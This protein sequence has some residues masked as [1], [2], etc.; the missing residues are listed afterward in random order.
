M[1]PQCFPAKYAGTCCQC[2]I[3]FGAGSPVAFTR[4]TVRSHRDGS[5]RTW[6]KHAT[7]VRHWDCRPYMAARARQMQLAEVALDIAHARAL[8]A[9]LGFDAAQTAAYEA[10]GYVAQ[11]ELARLAILTA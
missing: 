2:R 8:P 6:D 9:D 10:S 4:V 3:E 5:G 7:K 11:L 1:T